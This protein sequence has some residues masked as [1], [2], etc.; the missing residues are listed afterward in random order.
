M[1]RPMNHP[2]INIGDIYD[3]L[4]VIEEEIRNGNRF[5]KMWCRKCGR[6]KNLPRNCLYQ[7]KGT[8]H[9]ACGKGLKMA[10]KKFHSTWCGIRSRTTNPNYAHYADYGWRGIRSDAFENFIDF[11]DTM[12]ASY[13]E[14]KKHCSSDDVLSIDRI[15]VNGNYEPSNC[16]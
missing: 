7:H 1:G 15:D 9:K 6:E 13:I 11:Y 2:P 12:Y 14:V 4:E 16:R 5:Y 8:T 3:D 10:D